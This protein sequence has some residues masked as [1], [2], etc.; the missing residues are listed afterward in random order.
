MADGRSSCGSFK[1][2]ASIALLFI[3]AVI[4]RENTES[5]ITTWS[6]QAGNV[7]QLNL[8]VE[9]VPN[10][11]TSCRSRR[12]KSRAKRFMSSRF[13]YSTKGSSSFNLERSLL[14]CGDISSNPG[15]KG[16]KSSPKF[17]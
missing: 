8:A 2:L 17:P 11:I 10:S 7:H 14:V 15:P 4:I 9:Y 12:F 6:F 3:T 13:Q 5:Y 16:K 1:P